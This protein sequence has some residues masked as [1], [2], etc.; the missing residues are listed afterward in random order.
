MDAQ[1]ARPGTADHAAPA[2]AG[3]HPEPLPVVPTWHA[4]SGRLTAR[5]RWALDELAGRHGMGTAAVGHG[6]GHAAVALEIG[7]GTGEAAL[8]LAAARPDLLVVA[9]DVHKASLARLLLDLEATGTPNVR[10]AGG[11]GRAVLEALTP[12][13]IRKWVP[14]AMGL[15][16]SFVVPFANSLSFFIGAL[17]AWVMLC[18]EIMQICGSE[19]RKEFALRPRVKES[20]F[21]ELRK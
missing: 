6:E 10:V 15:G 2:P 9:A 11:D 13:R 19:H 5:K 16:L 12:E 21:P 18:A 20:Y 7:A 4:R 14:S 8:A 1:H 17:I 3:R